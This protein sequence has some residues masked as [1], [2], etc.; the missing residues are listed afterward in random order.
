MSGARL[1]TDA[2]GPTCIF[3]TVVVAK[4][5]VEYIQDA[6]RVPAPRRF[7]IFLPPYTMVQAVLEHCDVTTQGIAFRPDS[8][9]HLESGAI[10]MPIESEDLPQ[11]PA[12]IARLVARVKGRVDISRARQPQPLAARV[13]SILDAEYDTP[14]AIADIATRV[15]TSPAVLARSFKG[16]YGMPPVKYRHH[17][18]IMDALLRF[19]EGEVPLS[20]C[21]DVGFDDVSRFYK[22][23]RQVACAPPSTFRP[24][25]SRN[26]KT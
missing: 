10:L 15:R 2:S 25:R 22:I 12:D 8:E 14:L 18:R 23:L 7:A 9:L 21:H 4:G 11:Q 16:S 5:Q 24:H 6:R 20:V 19:A 13:K 3:A 1:G 26:A 17:L